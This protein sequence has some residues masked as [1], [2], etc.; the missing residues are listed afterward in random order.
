[1]SKDNDRQMDWSAFRQLDALCGDLLQLHDTESVLRAL[2]A[3]VYALQVRQVVAPGRALELAHAGY[4]RPPAIL[5]TRTLFEE[6]DELHATIDQ[7]KAEL[8][9][10]LD[11]AR[12]LRGA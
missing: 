6:L 2:G 1:M 3:T 12:Q 7:L 4:L 11:V 5:D 10:S 9:Q 8:Q